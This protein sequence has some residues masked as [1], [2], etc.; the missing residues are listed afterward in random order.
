M[1]GVRGKKNGEQE[2]QL[3]KNEDQ[4]SGPAGNRTLDLIH[5]KDALYH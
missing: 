1:L 3:K 5:A 2:E 4:K